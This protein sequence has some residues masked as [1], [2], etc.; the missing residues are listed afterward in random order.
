[1]TRAALGDRR[2]YRDMLAL[3]LPVALQNLLAI[4]AAAV[5]TIMV[6]GVSIDGQ[7]DL[8]VAAVGVAGQFSSLLFSAYFG[9]AAGGMIFFAQYHGADDEQGILKAYGLTLT[10]MMLAGLLFMCGAVFAPDAV[11]RLYAAGEDKAAL[12]AVGAQYLRIAGFAF[13]FQVMGQAMAY[14]MRSVERVRLPMFASIASVLT[15]TFLNWVL[16]YGKFGLPALGVRGAAIATLISSILVPAIMWAYSAVDRRAL[17]M[18]V[19][20]QFAWSGELIRLYFKKSYPI[21]LNEILYGIG[22]MLINRILGFQQMPALVAMVIFRS[23]E[24]FVFAFFG[25]FSNAGAVIIGKEVGAGELPRA[26]ANAKR[27]AWQCP[28]VTVCVCLV[29]LALRPQIV[30]GYHMGAEAGEYLC[31]MLEIYLI[32]GT[33]RTAN[34]IININFRAAGESVYGTVLELIALLGFTVP[35][36]Y[37]VGVALKLPFL[38][39][40]AAIFVEELL[41]LFIGLRHLR[42][43]RFIKPVTELG[44]EQLGAFFDEMK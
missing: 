17:V 5:D 4:C 28:L 40:F 42:S 19:R 37:I 43:G 1:M 10:A 31:R 8:A 11:M 36:V 39:V 41:K 9:F 34:Y 15:N 22:Q 12:R 21:I 24:G 38:F 14:L 27:M 30:R 35:L 29:I 23:I 3:G 33:I 2:Y 26:H 16:I 7:R 32:G 44:R 13:P 6:S 18:R 20:E 25:G